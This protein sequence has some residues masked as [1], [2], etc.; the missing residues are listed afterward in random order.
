LIVLCPAAW[1]F[2]KWNQNP[3]ETPAV[4]VAPFRNLSDDETDEFFSDGLTDEIIDSLARVPGLRVM[5]HGSSFQLKDKPIDIRQVG[6]QFHVHAVLEGSVRRSGNRLR[7]TAQLGDGSS[8]YILWSQSYER[9]SQDVL[10]IQ[11]EI[12]KAIANAL[13]VKLAAK[14]GPQGKTPAS[15]NPEAY[16]DYLKGRYFRNKLGQ[17]NVIAA[18]DFLNQAI[19]KDPGYA[20]AYADL[21]HCYVMMANSES[22]PLSECIP[23]I[24]AADEKALE[25][26]DTLG[27]ANLGL[28]A[29]SEYAFNWPAAEQKFTRALELSPGSAYAHHLYSEYLL[30]MGR[31]EE[32]LAQAKEAAQLDP[33]SPF[34]AS[35]LGMALYHTRKFDDAIAAFRIALALDPDFY[36]ARGGLGMSYIRKGLHSQ[37]LNEIQAAK[38][39]YYYKLIAAYGHALSGDF[40]LARQIV[41]EMLEKAKDRPLRAMAVAQVF[42]GLNEKDQ[43][44]E[45]LQKAV[46]EP[47]PMLRLKTDPTYDPLRSD[48]RFNKLLQKM[49]LS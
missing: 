13:G 15:V 20:P 31:T 22:K 1:F 48:P 7:I 42:I 27:E 39:P 18:I 21:A 4:L 8:G 19:N 43:A 46:Q 44:F 3:G 24:R 45:W 33:V 28:A 2:L 11:R 35:S 14:N 41:T 9:D 40:P 6:K 23:K 17:D 29:I 37:G 12:S 26:D 34:M 16:R 47:D 5:A 38:G 36:M 32:A 49:N 10:V 25:L 30:R